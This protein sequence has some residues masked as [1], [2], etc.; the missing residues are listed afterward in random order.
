VDKG[1]EIIKIVDARTKI[2][3][4][5]RLSLIITDIDDMI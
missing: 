3:G 2:A 4:I 5:N 1:P